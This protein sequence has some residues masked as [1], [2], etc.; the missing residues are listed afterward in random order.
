VWFGQADG[1][2]LTLSFVKRF[3][4]GWQRE[5]QPGHHV[6]TASPLAKRKG[7]RGVNGLCP[8]GVAAIS[9]TISEPAWRAKP[10]SYLI[11]TD[12]KMIP[13]GC[14]LCEAYLDRRAALKRQRETRHAWPGLPSSSPKNERQIHRAIHRTLL[15]LQCSLKK[16]DLCL[17]TIR[18]AGGDQSVASSHHSV[19]SDVLGHPHTTRSQ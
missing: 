8:W 14:V 19:S 15:L 4:Y 13:R 7:E 10:S 12:E 18:S 1:R 17:P 9:A 16:S 6:P 11:A 3:R 5:E 2:E